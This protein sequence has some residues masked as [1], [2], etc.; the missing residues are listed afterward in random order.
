MAKQLRNSNGNPIL[1]IPLLLSS[2]SHHP[3][4]LFASEKIK[5]ISIPI[6]IQ[7]TGKSLLQ[8]QIS[9]FQKRENRMYRDGMIP[10]VAKFKYH[11]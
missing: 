5:P 7:Q 11:C 4:Q 1:N 9:Q 2:N 8:Q 10:V 6:A 3:K